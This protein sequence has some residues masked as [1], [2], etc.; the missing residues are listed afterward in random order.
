[1]G[2]SIIDLVDRV[3]QEW[4]FPLPL[5][6]GEGYDSREGGGRAKQ[7]ARAEG[8]GYENHEFTPSPQSSPSSE[9]E[10]PNRK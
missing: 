5:S 4:A 6:R 10:F 7:D 9:S 1:M 8:E 3:Y 2:P